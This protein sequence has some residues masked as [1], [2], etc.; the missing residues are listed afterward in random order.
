MSLTKRWRIIAAPSAPAITFRG[1]SWSYGALAQR[2]AK[3]RGL[4]ANQGLVSGEIVALHM[5][6]DVDSLVLHL[7]ALDLGLVTLPLNP[8]YAAA[9]V[10][11]MLEDAD[12]AFCVVNAPTARPSIASDQIK[13]RIDDA[14]PADMAEAIGDGTPAVLCYTS[15]TTGRPKGALL[16]HGQ[17]AAYVSALHTAWK[18]TERDILLHALPLFHVHGL[19]VAQWGALW[20]GAHAVWM[21]RFSPAIFIEQIAQHNAT[22]AMGVPTFYHRLLPLLGDADLSSIR[23]LTS[24]SAPLPSTTWQAVESLTGHQVVERYGM[25]EI[26][27]VFSNPLDGPRVPGSIGVPLDGVEAQIRTRDGQQCAH[28]ELGELHIRGPSVFSGYLGRPKAT[29]DALVEGW[30]ATGDLGHMDSRGYV[31]LAGRRTELILRGGLNVYPAEVERVLAE[32]PGVDEVAV[33]GVADPDLGQRVH[34]ALVVS[35][36][37]DVESLL[38]RAKSKLARY[39]LPDRLHIMDALPRNA[40]GKVMRATLSRDFTPSG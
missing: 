13:G 15:G 36:P 34:A 33:F 18:W 9:E 23:L 39:K 35:A 40:M 28:G 30:M 16:T 12:A 25:T 29:A 32:A 21:D 22:I 4:L 27:I 20:A 26:G 2:V 1:R 7:A 37:I 10:T 8:S 17:I 3:A 6:K 24:G 14:T 38:A 5:H 31:F 19:F 11:W